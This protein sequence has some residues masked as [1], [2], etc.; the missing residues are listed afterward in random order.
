MSATSLITEVRAAGGRIEV[1]DGK[2]RLTAPKP[3]P[4]DLV[5]LIKAHKPELLAALCQN[6]ETD[7]DEAIRE[8]LEERAAIQEY[9][10]GLTREQ[11][12][13]EAR[14]ALRVYEYRLTDNPNAWL[15]M[16]APRCDLDQAT[17]TC[18]KRFGPDR[19]L[20]VR[21]YKTR[22]IS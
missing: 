4:D 22:K 11:A 13:T 3:L 10:G 14:Q 8:H 17:R 12:E 6:E 21:E 7:Y 15:V 2:L 20:E 19:V 5:D 1:Y 9:D 18:R 16:I